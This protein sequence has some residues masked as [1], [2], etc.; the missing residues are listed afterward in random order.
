M[1][2]LAQHHNHN[3]NKKLPLELSNV[4][5]SFSPS[6]RMES[7]QYKQELQGRRL[8]RPQMVLGLLQRRRRKR[9][10]YTEIISLETPSEFLK[11]L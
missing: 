11:P 7:V 8:R 5:Q 1:K 2:V 6:N 10:P 3:L 9:R 4:A